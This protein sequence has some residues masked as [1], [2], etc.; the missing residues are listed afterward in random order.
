[1]CT[2]P[3][4]DCFAEE[5]VKESRWYD[6]GVF[7]GISAHDLDSI[8]NVYSSNGTTRC[9][10]EMHKCLMKTAT[11]F[12]WDDV[13]TA[14]SRMDNFQLAGYIDQKY[15][16]GEEDSKRKRK[17]VKRDNYG[18]DSPLQRPII[19]RPL[20]NE[21]ENILAIFAMLILRVK[22]AFAYEKVPLGDLQFFLQE[23]YSIV[24]PSNNELNS[25]DTIFIKLQPHYS[26]L[27]YNVFCI[28]IQNFLAE[29]LP[30]QEK[31]RHYESELQKFKTST[32]MKDL[33][34]TDSLDGQTNTDGGKRI[35]IKI[36]FQEFWSSV[37]IEKFERLAKSVFEELHNRAVLIRVEQGCICVTWMISE[38]CSPEMV[39][40]LPMT[41]GFLRELGI[42]SISFNYTLYQL[43]HFGCSNLISAIV[44]A[45]QEKKIKILEIY[46]AVSDLISMSTQLSSTEK[47]SICHS[48]DSDDF[49]C[50]SYA[51]Y[52]GH[53]DVVQFLLENGS[54]PSIQAKSGI[55]PLIAASA[56]GHNEIVDK[57]LS[58]G[59]NVNMST[60]DGLTAIY[61]SSIKGHSNIFKMLLNSGKADPEL[62]NSNS[63]VSP[64]IAACDR[65]HKDIVD[66]L[67]E[68]KVIVDKQTKDGRT[69]LYQASIHG[70]TNIVESLLKVNAD[71]NIPKLKGI[72]PLMTACWQ[73][74]F[75]TVGTLLRA[76]ANAHINMVIQHFIM[77][78]LEGNMTLLLIFSNIMWI[79][80]PGT[81]TG[82][83]L[84]PK[85]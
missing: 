60:D 62:G 28:L 68:R 71:P 42:M 58:A 51:S 6:L 26:F 13:A 85:T 40:K 52:C 22:N 10:I 56:E 37:V 54:Q 35:E 43:S 57:L 30:L 65:G 24:P 17:R 25:L 84:H 29:K 76:G 41:I 75:E 77:L 79:S 14:L 1:M 38:K 3:T 36:K 53:T 64:L 19:G 11:I 59:A 49:Y 31:I 82:I 50:L 46:L 55:T 66:L 74:H 78:P 73:G 83:I 72:T 2:L 67:L 63:N 7:L 9:L 12:T 39:K 32:K 69:A 34:K 33:I 16:S 4:V 81:V 45:I 18:D 5:L 80:T 21:F 61:F 47:K 44:Q 15:G 48:K 20:M 27:S 23:M 70:Y 8:G